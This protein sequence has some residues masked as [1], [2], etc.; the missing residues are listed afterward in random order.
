M[1]QPLRVSPASAGDVG[2][3]EIRVLMIERDHGIAALAVAIDGG[4]VHRDD[5]E[6]AVVIAVDQTGAAAHGFDDVFLFRSGNVGNG[7]AG[8]FGHVFKSRD[9]A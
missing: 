4:T 5:V 2:E 8:F 6:F 3:F 9:R 7:Q 1:P